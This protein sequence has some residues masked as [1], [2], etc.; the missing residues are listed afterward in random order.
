ME[1]QFSEEQQAI[2]AGFKKI[3]GDLVTDESLKA[4]QKEGRWMHDA[5]WKALADAEMLG[6]AMPEEVGG[7]GFGL[8]EL[9]LLLEQVGRTV[10]PIPALPTLVSAGL[11]IAKFGT[12]EQ[13][14]RLLTGVVEGDTILSAALV[15]AGRDPLSPVATATKTDS[16]WALNGSFTNVQYA[17]VAKRIL[18][19]ARTDD[20]GA[21]GV[22]L[23]DPAATGVLLERQQ[24]TNGE[25][26]SRLTLKDA[27]VPVSDVLGDP[28]DGAGILKFAV[29]RTLLGMC[30]MEYGVARAA[31]I[32]TAKYAAER[33]QFGV[34]IGTF[35]AV[36]QRLADAYIDVSAMEV[37]MLQAAWKLDEGRDADQD[38]AVAKFWAAEAGARVLYAAQHVHGGMGFDRDYPLY[39]YFLTS[40]HL[41]FTLG[42]ANESLDRLG[43]LLMA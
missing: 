7:V 37:S 11:P 1:F 3:L 5:A 13:R 31:L 25:P 41:E 15:G 33:K 30:A 29:D 12:D 2:G 18:V 24:G 39:R 35:Q 10:A 14:Q 4:L 27:P 21:V 32:M 17:D 36:K 8:Q 9:C 43:Q 19:A 42:G 40:K 20:G 22:F 23:L 16:G 28:T 34:A 6:L 26:L 38:L